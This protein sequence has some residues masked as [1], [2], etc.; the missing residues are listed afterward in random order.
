MNEREREQLQ[1]ELVAEREALL[2][3][4]SHVQQ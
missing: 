4:V 1:V 3:V 2:A